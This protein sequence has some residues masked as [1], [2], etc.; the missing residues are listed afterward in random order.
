MRPVAGSYLQTLSRSA[1][2]FAR[3]RMAGKGPSS[4]TDKQTSNGEIARSA[5]PNGRAEKSGQY[6]SAPIEEMSRLY[7]GK[8][9]DK[10]WG[11][12]GLYGSRIAETKLL[13][14]LR[15]TV[16]P[17]RLLRI[18]EVLQQRCKRVQC[19]FENVSDPANG[20][21]CLRTMEA[22]GLTDAHVVEAYEPFRVSEGITMSADKWMTVTKY[23]HCL[24]A[25]QQL[26]KDGFTIVATC[27]DDDA[28]PLEEVDFKSMEKICI[29]FGNEERGLSKV[30]RGEADH[31]VYI[32]MTGFSQSFNISVSCGLM[33]MHARHLGLIKPDL[34]DEEITKLYKKWLLMSCK[35]AINLLNRH[36]LVDEANDYL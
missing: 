1:S 6:S 27:L 32:P 18:E 19:L 10:S 5:F 7:M 35:N 26:K 17:K 24:D 34:T 22:F 12:T 31:K 23:K 2:T 28:L 30:L 15:S 33:V 25:A 4:S 9:P 21:A 14:L 16:K 36:G 3:L 29:M 20:A 11:P 13:S 8:Y